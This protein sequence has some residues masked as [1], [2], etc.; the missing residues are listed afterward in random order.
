[1]PP[2]SRNEP[3]SINRRAVKFQVDAALSKCY[4][5]SKFL[6]E[7]VMASKDKKLPEKRDDSAASELLHRL[8]TR[9]FLFIGTMIVLIIVIIAFVFVPAMVPNAR[10][11][12]ELTFGYYNKVPISYVP[13]NYFYQTQQM[14]TQ[15]RQPAPDNPNYMDTITE[16]WRDA[17]EAAAIHLGILDEMKQ[18]GYVVPEDVVDREMAELP[19]FQENGRFSSAKYRAMDNNT[20]MNLRKQVK[21]S[22]VA[23]CYYSDL[24]NLKTPSKET[25]FVSAM[26]SPK[27][28]FDLAVFPLSS[29]PD[30]EIA[31]FAEANPSLFMMLRLSSITVNSE[32]EARQ[33]LDSIKNGIVPFEEAAKANSQDWAADRGGDMGMFMTHELNWIIRDEQIL[34]TI[35]GLAKGE[36]SDI[37]NVNNGWAFF[38]IDEAAYPVNADDISQRTRIRNYI[39]QNSRGQIEDWAISEAEKFSTLVNE[40]DFETAITEGKIIKRSIGPISLNYGNSLI[41]GSLESSGVSELSKE[42]DN[43]FFWKAAFTTPLKSLSKPLVVK[44]N[45]IV[46]FPLEESSVDEEEIGQIETYYPYWLRSSMDSAY[47][48]FFLNN[49]KMDNRFQATFRKLWR[50]N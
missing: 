19:H 32:N 28:T 7:F 38:R 47:R 36:I 30:S 6:Q 25:S 16:I 21:E 44:D 37:Y 35:V 42:G 29:Y 15:R 45:V 3:V 24:E 50:E 17:F 48:S 43:Q 31:S 5:Q 49:E 46:L 12:G 2:F 26:A 4:S 20:L 8:K 13:N 40:K 33:I 27:R 9:P 10:R 34:N 18:A 11:G 1:V 14:L 23:K 39:M 41:F 22:I